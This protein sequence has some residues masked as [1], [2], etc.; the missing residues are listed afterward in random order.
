LPPP[1]PVNVDEYSYDAEDGDAFEIA[2]MGGGVFEAAGGLVKRL[3]RNVSLDN[4]ESFRY[5]QRIL[6]EKGVIDALRKKGAKDGDTVIL[7]DIEFE[8]VD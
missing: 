4:D 3:E 5:F 8:F 1:A 2:D 7:G 6:R